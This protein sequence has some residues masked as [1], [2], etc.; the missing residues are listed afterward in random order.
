MSKIEWTDKTWNVITGCTQTSPAC[1]NCY[2][3]AMTRRLKA[4]KLKKYASG[5]DKIVF[6]EDILNEI[7]T[8]KYP[9][10]IKI[11]VN[12]MSDTFHEDISDHKIKKL[13]IMMNQRVDL[14][15]QVLT[16]RAKR[17]FEFIST[18]KDILT[19]N[20][21]L[22]VT[23]EN[24]EMFNQRVKYLAPLKEMQITT[25]VSC[26]PL[27][28]SIDISEYIDCINW[29]IVGGEKAYKKGRIMEYEWVKDI[30][31]QCQKNQTP[32]F[33]KQWG[34][35]EKKIKLSM[36]GIENDLLHKIENTKEFPI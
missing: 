31:S 23:A 12:S 4:M 8:K 10:G 3:K 20:I 16:K 27:L 15:F 9:H 14:T 2:A 5:W 32:F 13:F 29:V 17:M 28:E 26:E 34:D 24:Q 22:G 33:F 30:Y 36:Q 19:P 6:H 7:L 11:F 25:F 21:Q 18:N 1:Q 35:C